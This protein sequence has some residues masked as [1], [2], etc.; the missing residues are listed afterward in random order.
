MWRATCTNFQCDDCRSL[1][2]DKGLANIIERA[3]NNNQLH[4][5][6]T[7]NCYLTDKQKTAEI[8]EM[9]MH[10]RLLELDQ[11]NYDRRLEVVCK[12]RDDLT[13]LKVALSENKIPRVHHI[14]A[15][16]NKENRSTSATVE[17]LSKAMS[18]CYLFHFGT[19]LQ[20]KPW[21]NLIQGRHLN[22]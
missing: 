19:I 18:S 10:N 4:L 15:R 14:L 13:R 17:I 20:K 5:G 11:F 21:S 8:Q 2:Q 16:T 7:N 6:T 9:C 1:S 12:E 3:K 22:V